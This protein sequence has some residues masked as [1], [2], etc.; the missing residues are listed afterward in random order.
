[1]KGTITALLVHD[2]EPYFRTLESI[3]KGQGIA[4]REAR[5]C[6]EAL[7]L[8]TPTDAPQ[9][10]FADAELPDGTW[11]DVLNLTTTLTRNSAKVVVVSHLVD[12]KL[13]LNALE[14][15]AFDFI[16]PPF[17]ASDVAHIVRSATSGAVERRRPPEA[18][19][20]GI[21]RR[22]MS[23]RSAGGPRASSA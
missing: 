16:V 6:G 12:L 23:A 19:D 11:V 21:P 2:G 8:L 14:S 20:T 17:E 18:P 7:A 3:L 9:L 13:Y 15:G 22:Q 4:S 10:V 5:S 1:M